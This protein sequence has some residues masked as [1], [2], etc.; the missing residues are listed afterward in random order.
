MRIE[1]INDHQ[2]RC[3]INANDLRERKMTLKDVRYGNQATMDL[4]HEVVEEASIRYGF[5]AEEFPLMIEA[6]PLNE[7]EIMITVSAIEESEEMDPH[8]ARFVPLE[9]ENR[10][11]RKAGPFTEAFL[12]TRDDSHALNSCVFL[13]KDI[14]EVMAFSK[15]ASAFT[16]KS[17]LY[18]NEQDLSFY[19]VMLRPED[20]T[21]KDFHRIVNSLNEFGERMEAGQVLTAFLSEH[22]KPVMEDP[23]LSLGHA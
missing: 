8:F 2:I 16:G 17:L 11:S 10:N 9:E 15:Q 4:F 22:E 6:V 14:D 5:N 12:D 13:L 23:I 20:M 3:I 21:G 18:R 7:N 1:K 19:L